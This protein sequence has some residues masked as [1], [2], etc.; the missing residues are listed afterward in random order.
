MGRYDS[1]KTR[2]AP[3][4]DRLLDR[5]PTG[6]SWLKRLMRL[7]SRRNVA[8]VPSSVGEL[9]PGHPRWWGRQERRLAP[10][11][12]LL[13]W[14]IQNIA[15]EAVRKAGGSE[16]TRRMRRAL[17]RGERDVVQEALARLRAGQRGKRWFVSRR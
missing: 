2:V 4:F 17:A 11:L 8:D 12:E 10:P 9:V 3:V 1:S 5:D 7:G 14:L 6:I 16:K 13:E 15:E